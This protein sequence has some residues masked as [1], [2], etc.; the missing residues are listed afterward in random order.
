MSYGVNPARLNDHYRIV[1]KRQRLTVIEKMAN[2]KAS[3]WRATQAGQKAR[4]HTKDYLADLD[5]GNGLT[6]V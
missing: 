4:P 1:G 2:G 3:Q 5:R 6:F